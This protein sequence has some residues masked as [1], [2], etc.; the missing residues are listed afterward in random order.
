MKTEQGKPVQPEDKWAEPIKN[1]LNFYG[2]YFTLTNFKYLLLIT[3]NLM[4]LFTLNL[5]HPYVI[6][7]T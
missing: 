1:L 6:I 4:Y 2:I 3:P 7:V 5:S